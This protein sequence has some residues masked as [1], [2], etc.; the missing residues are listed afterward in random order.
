MIDAA[1][2]PIVLQLSK[3]FYAMV[4]IVGAT[5]QYLLALYYKR[6]PRTN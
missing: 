5:A 2:V 6:T 3:L 4:G 1:S